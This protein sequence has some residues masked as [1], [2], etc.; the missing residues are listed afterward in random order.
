MA[1]FGVCI[2]V[3]NFELAL[4]FNT[5]TW[6]GTILLLTGPVM[7]FLLYF[8]MSLVFVSGICQIFVPSFK[9]ILIWIVVYFCVAQTFVVEYMYN[10]IYNKYSSYAQRKRR[11]Q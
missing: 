7:Y 6:P 8:L 1:I 2:F 11:E 10:Y 4:R 5:H 9:M 3:A